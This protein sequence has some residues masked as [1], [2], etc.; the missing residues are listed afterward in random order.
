MNYRVNRRFLETPSFQPSQKEIGPL[1]KQAEEILAKAGFKNIELKFDARVSGFHL[2]AAVPKDMLQ[3]DNF[4][5]AIFTAA[6]KISETAGRAITIEYK[7]GD[8]RQI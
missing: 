2:K 4:L 3:D 8:I 1:K 5:Q 7:D 6:C